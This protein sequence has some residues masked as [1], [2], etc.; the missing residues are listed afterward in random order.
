LAYTGESQA[1]GPARRA[2]GDTRSGADK[3]E[4]A[5]AGGCNTE[6]VRHILQTP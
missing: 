4:L 1:G 6:A 3:I 5:G 2:G